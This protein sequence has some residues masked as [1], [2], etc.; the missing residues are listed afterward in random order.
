MFTIVLTIHVLLALGLVAIILVQHGKGADA[1]AA[2]GS[3]ASG[4]VF[5]ASGTSSFL[6]KLTVWLATAFFTTSL[7]LAF[8]ASNSS[9]S[10][11]ASGLITENVVKQDTVPSN[12]NTQLEDIPEQ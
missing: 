3:G 6:Y 2:F 5:G 11:D 1:G 8:I 9:S 7:S 4:S 10:Y 12:N